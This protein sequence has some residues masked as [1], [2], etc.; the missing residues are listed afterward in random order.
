MK[1]LEDNNYIQRCQKAQKDLR[2]SSSPLVPTKEFLR[3]L[4]L[5]DLNGQKAPPVATPPNIEGGDYPQGHAACDPSNILKI[6]ARPTAWTK[7]V[8]ATKPHAMKIAQSMV[9][10]RFALF[11]FFFDT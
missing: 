10:G 3:A 4:A 7:I 8:T 1:W 11:V 2:G 6:K 9:P 5:L